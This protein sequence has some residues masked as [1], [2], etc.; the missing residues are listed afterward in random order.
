MSAA[1]DSTALR[2]ITSAGGLNALLDRWGRGGWG[3]PSPRPNCD[4]LYRGETSTL[5]QGKE[6]KRRENK[7]SGL[8]VV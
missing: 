5:Q 1:C 6:G 4:A 2:A 3:W 8:K 7:N